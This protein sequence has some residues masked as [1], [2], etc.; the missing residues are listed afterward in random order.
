MKSGQQIWWG[1]TIAAIMMKITTLEQKILRNDRT[2]CI[3]T[4]IKYTKLMFRV[5]RIVP[6]VPMVVCVLSVV[7]FAFVVN[8]IYCR[9]GCDGTVDVTAL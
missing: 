8:G 7:F 2:V 4:N 9:A 5:C 1:D 3:E 6:E